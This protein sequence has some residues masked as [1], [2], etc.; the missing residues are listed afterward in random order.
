MA[1]SIP[2]PSHTGHALN[3][4]AFAHAIRSTEELC[5]QLPKPAAATA[6]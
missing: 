3:G 4:P 1:E 2:T 5:A 6:A